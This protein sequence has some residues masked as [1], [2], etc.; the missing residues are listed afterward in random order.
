MTTATCVKRS[1]VIK[2][3]E[4]YTAATAAGTLEPQKSKSCVITH[5]LDGVGV[6]NG[7]SSIDDTIRRTNS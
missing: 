4:E 7:P 3:E 5:T 1:E 2:Q 6:V